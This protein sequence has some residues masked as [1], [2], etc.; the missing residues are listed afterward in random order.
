M[1]IIQQMFLYQ[2]LQI[3]FILDLISQNPN[4][5][6]YIQTLQH[7]SSI[8][9]ISIQN[10][11]QNIQP[12]ITFRH[13]AIQFYNMQNTLN[14]FITKLNPFLQYSKNNLLHLLN[15]LLLNI[16]HPYSKTTFQTIALI[17]ITTDKSRSHPT[18]N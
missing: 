6:R 12:K 11:H 15:I 17:P 18:L 8:M 2:L 5:F 1:L 16:A 3:I 14:N 7:I 10:L 4:I 9:I 13:L